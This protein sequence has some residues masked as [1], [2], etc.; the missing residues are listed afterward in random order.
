MNELFTI[1]YAC[2]LMMECMMMASTIDRERVSV[3]DFLQ[4][5]RASKSKSKGVVSRYRVSVCK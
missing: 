1:F 2:I 4:W 5:E 3:C